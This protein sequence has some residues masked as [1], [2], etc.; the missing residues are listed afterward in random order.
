MTLMYQMFFAFRDDQGGLVHVFIQTHIIPPPFHTKA[1]QLGSAKVGGV[2][3]V[4]KFLPR[5]P[6]YLETT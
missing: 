2:W 5:A 6:G 4:G 3:L 1:S